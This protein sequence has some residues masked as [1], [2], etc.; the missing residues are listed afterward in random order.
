M[1]LF[2]SILFQMSPPSNLGMLSQRINQQQQQQQQQATSG[3]STI[4][5][6]VASRG[7]NNSMGPSNQSG[8]VA[9]QHKRSL[10]FNHHLS[11][12]QYTHTQHPPPHQMHHPQQPPS[13]PSHPVAVPNHKSNLVQTSNSISKNPM[14][15]H[16]TAN[17]MAA[18]VRTGNTKGENINDIF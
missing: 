14:P 11:Y 17:T 7:E 15:A 10:S 8:A 6:N 16:H 9:S 13:L 18:N 5:T 3:Q 1:H 4:T 2:L 12:N